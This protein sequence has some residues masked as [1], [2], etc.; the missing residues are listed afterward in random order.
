[1]MN[2]LFNSDI[3]I[4]FDFQNIVNIITD[5]T[6]NIDKY[7]CKEFVKQIRMYYLKKEEYDNDKQITTI[8]KIRNQNKLLDKYNL[9]YK[10]G[11]ELYK[12]DKKK[13]SLQI[14]KNIVIDIFK[15]FED[16]KK[17]QSSYISFNNDSYYKLLFQ[18]ASIYY[19]EREFFDSATLLIFVFNNCKNQMIFVQMKLL[20]DNMGFYFLNNK[21]EKSDNLTIALFEISFYYKNPLFCSK[22]QEFE[23][24]VYVLMRIGDVLLISKKYKEAEPYYMKIIEIMNQH[25]DIYNNINEIKLKILHN[26]GSLYLYEDNY[27]DAKD[28]LLS[29]YNFRRILLGNENDNTL[30]TL[31]KLASAEA[32]MKEYEVAVKRLTYIISVFKKKYNMEYL[33]VVDAQFVLGKIYIDQ[34]KLEAA[35][36]LFINIKNIYEKNYEY[37]NFNIFKVIDQLANID[38]KQE[39]YDKAFLEWSNIIINMDNNQEIDVILFKYDTYYNIGF[40]LY[41]MAKYKSCENIMNYIYN[42]SYKLFGS[43]HKSTTVPAT[44][45]QELNLNRYESYCKNMN[46]KKTS[47]IKKFYIKLN[48]D[49]FF[50]LSFYYN[51]QL[52]DTVEY[53]QA[54]LKIINIPENHKE[55]DSNIQSGTIKVVFKE[56]SQKN[57]D[58]FVPPII[59]KSLN[60][61]KIEETDDQSTTT[62]SSEENKFTFKDGLNHALSQGIDISE[63]IIYNLSCAYYK[64]GDFDNAEEMIQQLLRKYKKKTNKKVIDIILYLREHLLMIYYRQ[65]KISLVKEYLDDLAFTYKK[66]YGIDH[67]NY[68]TIIN[69]Y[70]CI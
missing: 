44:F 2:E 31:F 16:H 65:N 49:Y 47:E 39:K 28:I 14:F 7:D 8:I 23:R 18:V 34:E 54:L 26:L 50:G 3:N 36:E 56:S 46:N 35:R 9:L 15:Y 52:E 68:K 12:N 67:E 1:M 37:S 38:F 17:L 69:L 40:A 45:L 60:I 62:E 10:E 20:C 70:K 43:E 63:N 13:E 57:K 27:K 30:K 11:E 33:F 55:F 25:Q 32:K 6:F 19:K 5:D 51:N 42:F 53:Y 61:I 24:Y 64:L 58:E 4:E 29:C 66:N 59:K 21:H 22:L 48:I 41:K